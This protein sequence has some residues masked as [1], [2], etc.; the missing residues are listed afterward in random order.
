MTLRTLLH[1]RDAVGRF[2]WHYTPIDWK[3]CFAAVLREN[4][5][6]DPLTLRVKGE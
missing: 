5:R 2:L 1:I 3:W 4:E 6:R